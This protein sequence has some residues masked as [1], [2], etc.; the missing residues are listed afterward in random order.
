MLANM[1]TD[2]RK[3]TLQ[4]G[5][6]VLRFSGDMNRFTRGFTPQP[7]IQLIGRG[8]NAAAIAGHGHS[9]FCPALRYRKRLAQ[10]VA[11]SFQPLSNAERFFTFGTAT[12]PLLLLDA[13]LRIA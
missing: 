9:G 3:S 5:G 8:V 2:I 6:Q 11:I 12:S 10:N 7:A 1:F 4:I 13:W